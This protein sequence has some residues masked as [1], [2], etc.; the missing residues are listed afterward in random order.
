MNEKYMPQ[1]KCQSSAC[2]TYSLFIKTNLETSTHLQYC[3][4]QNRR[5]ILLYRLGERAKLSHNND[6]NW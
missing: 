1:S 3:A 4:M 2:D 5:I 6:I